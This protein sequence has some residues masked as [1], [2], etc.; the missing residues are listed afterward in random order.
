[1]TTCSALGP[2]ANLEPIPGYVLRERLGSGGFGEVWKAEAPGGLLK[3]IKFVYGTLDESRAAQEM[4]SLSRIRSVQHPFLL[5]IERIEVVNGHLI[6][7]SE[8]AG[9]SLMERFE[10]CRRDGLPGIPRE[11]LI[12]YVRDAAEVLDYLYEKH[13]LQHLDVKPENLLLVGSHIKVADFGLLKNLHDANMSLMSGLTP[14]YSPP[15]VLSGKPGRHSDQYSLAIVFQEMLTGEPPF[16]GRTAAQLAAQ[17]LHSPPSLSSLPISDQAVIARALAKKPESRYAN[18]RTMVEQLLMSACQRGAAKRPATPARSDKTEVL[19]VME[20]DRESSLLLPIVEA[21][22]CELTPLDSEVS[23]SEFGP[24]VFLGIGAIGRKV[25]TRL[26]QRLRDR[27]VNLQ[28]PPAIQFLAIDCDRSELSRGSAAGQSDALLARETLAIPLRSSAEYRHDAEKL[29]GWLER[30]WLYNVPRDLKTNGLRP[31]GRLALV[32]HEK[33]L[34]EHLRRVLGSAISDSALRSS[35]QATGLPFREKPPQVYLVSATGGG[36]GSGMLGDMA[37]LVRATL[38]DLGVSD[39]SVRGV[40]VHS[41]SKSASEHDM[42]VASTV[43][44]LS[45]LRDFGNIGSSIPQDSGSLSGNDAPYGPM[46]ADT[47]VIHL[48]DDLSNEQFERELQHVSDYLLFNTITPVASVLE[49]ARRIEHE[50]AAETHGVPRIRSVQLVRGAESGQISEHEFEQLASSALVRHWTEVPANSAEKKRPFADLESQCALIAEERELRFEP[51]LEQTRKIFE[52]LTQK[53]AQQVAEQLVD[54]LRESAPD[55]ATRTTLF[56]G[57]DADL[58]IVEGEE[59]SQESLAN[60]LANRT[61]MLATIQG[62]AIGEWIA[63][64]I[65]SPGLRVC[66]ARWSAKWFA[67]MLEGIHVRARS[68]VERIEDELNLIR[69]QGDRGTATA[70]SSRKPVVDSLSSELLDYANLRIQQMFH[71]SMQGAAV[72]IMTQLNVV[73]GQIRAVSEGLNRLSMHFSTEVAQDTAA[74]FSPTA[75]RDGV[76]IPVS[77]LLETDQALSEQLQTERSSFCQLF[78]R[79][80]DLDSTVQRLQVTIREA[81]LR[82][83]SHDMRFR[84][85]S[86]NPDDIKQ[87]LEHGRPRLAECGGALRWFVVAP[88]DLETDELNRQLGSIVSD[89]VTIIRDN[90][91]ELTICCEAERIPIDNV[92]AK[93][94]GSRQDILA[95]ARRLHTRKDVPWEL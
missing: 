41:T 11:E 66:G 33:S 95:V 26:K 14:M 80:G 83:H 44:C 56:S 68:F 52:E 21:S 16:A 31:Y 53:P 5:S 12:G 51:L 29:L 77:V 39:E 32:D 2:S 78:C 91:S 71:R 72:A 85:V 42:S 20:A 82:T 17:H 43:A 13:S 94:V 54:K 61:K 28:V 93:L 81:R 46:F 22:N 74:R 25:L 60:R 75:I 4:R 63:A 15:E 70:R 18:C 47:Y 35:E 69:S 50:Q 58:G 62:R 34:R 27:L 3:A 7:V 24:M 19:S 87:L 23:G 37:F 90:V 55:Q 9:S 92:M 30:K 48:G 79:P 8:L 67:N 84:E 45:E 6:I 10:E 88:P 89:P 73:V 57:I 64:Q 36:T 49:S 65:E 86:Q 40:L 76:L 1:M 38:R 59:Q